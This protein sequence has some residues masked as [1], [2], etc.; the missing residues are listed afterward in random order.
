MHEAGKRRNNEC[1]IDAIVA[2]A[3]TRHWRNGRRET[4]NALTAGE[5]AQGLVKLAKERFMWQSDNHCAILPSAGP[6]PQDCRKYNNTVCGLLMS[7]IPS[8]VN[9]MR[10]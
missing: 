7:A 1:G 10:L 4:L 6:P 5:V 9:Q 3:S 8:E 2:S